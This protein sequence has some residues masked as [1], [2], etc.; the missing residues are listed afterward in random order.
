MSNTPSMAAPCTPPHDGPELAGRRALVTGA[1]SGIGLATARALARN[2]AQ[3]AAVV[4]S[5]G[6][7]AVVRQFLPQAP[8]FVQD[9]LDD[10]GCAA[11]E[12]LGTGGPAPLIAAAFFGMSFAFALVVAASTPASP[13]S[14][15]PAWFMRY[16]GAGRSDAAATPLEEPS[17]CRPFSANARQQVPICW[18]V[19]VTLSFLGWLRSL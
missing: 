7:V 6:Q 10:E 17:P 16:L 1:G 9:L 4:Q 13:A 18:P 15:N 3:V 12:P 19:A 14:R 11:A 2:G 8:V 5:E